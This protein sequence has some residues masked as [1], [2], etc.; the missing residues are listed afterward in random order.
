LKEVE[1][2]NKELELVTSGEGIISSSS[3]KKKPATAATTK[4]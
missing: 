3:Q 2:V 1:K 4:R